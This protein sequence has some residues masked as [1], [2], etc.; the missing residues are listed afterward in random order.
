MD[1]KAVEA[2]PTKSETAEAEW[3]MIGSDSSRSVA[4]VGPTAM[5]E[6]V[7]AAR[8]KMI[9]MLYVQVRNF[10]HG[11]IFERTFREECEKA[12][13]AHTET[14]V[15]DRQTEMYKRAVDEFKRLRDSEVEAALK[16]KDEERVKKWATTV[17]QRDEEITRLRAQL[18]AAED[19]RAIGHEFLQAIKRL[20][21][22]ENWNESPVEVYEELHE[23]RDA[24]TAELERKQIC[25]ACGEET[26]AGETI[27]ALK[28]ASEQARRLLAKREETS[29]NTAWDFVCDPLWS[30]MKAALTASAPNPN[31]GE[32]K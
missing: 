32:N 26:I 21:P 5:S 8:N 15:K 13:A 17:A 19:E 22:Q 12:I 2:A 30:D 25:P 4:R 14:A 1:R 27:A 10:A 28:A 7:E 11:A 18:A 31:S 9:D 16:E 29:A 6:T 3:R 20:Q 24:L 23:E